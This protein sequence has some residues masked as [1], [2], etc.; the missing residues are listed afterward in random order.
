MLKV[1]RSI[2]ICD[3]DVALL[4]AMRG[5]ISTYSGHEVI[6][7]SDPQYAFELALRSKFDLFIFDYSMPDIR[8]D[9]LYNLIS[10]AYDV[11]KPNAR[12]IPPLILITGHSSE[13]EARKLLKMAGVRSIIPKPFDLTRMLDQVESSL[14]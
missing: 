10:K 3:D 11:E 9:I 5:A 2:L 12:V 6:G 14:N 13:P 4:N 7:S 8:G 1:A